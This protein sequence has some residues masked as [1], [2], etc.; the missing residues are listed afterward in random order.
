MLVA[1]HW[2]PQPY[3]DEYMEKGLKL[4]EERRALFSALFPWEDPNFR[5][6]PFMGPCISLPAIHPAGRARDD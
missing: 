4:F 1:S 6:R 3:S 2:G 5:L